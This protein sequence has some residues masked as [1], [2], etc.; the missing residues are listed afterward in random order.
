MAKTQAADR[1]KTVLRRLTKDHYKVPPLPEG[2]PALER[3]LALVLQMEGSY[4]AAE[5]AVKALKSRYP[6]WNECRVARQ[7]EVKEALQR[8]RVA[9]AG[10][11]A[12]LAQEFLR[13]VFGLQNHLDLDWLYDATSERREKLLVSL[14]MAPDHSGPVLDLDANEEDHLP[15]TV[16]LK[17]VLTRLGLVSAAR[18]SQVLELLEPV[19]TKDKEYPYHLALSIHGREVCDSKHPHCRQCQALDLCPHG[20]RLLNSKA[21]QSALEELGLKKKRATKKTPARKT[22]KKAA[23]KTAARKTKKKTTRKRASSGSRG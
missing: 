15:V 20:K 11:R 22:A 17:R 10:E 8:K 6:H 21:Y 23:K 19:I 5:R 12:A 2:T 4:A 9:S 18:D 7:F 16:D 1:L 13:R 14:T 3:V